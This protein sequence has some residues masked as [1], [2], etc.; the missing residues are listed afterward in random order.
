MNCWSLN[1]LFPS[2]ISLYSLS[3]LFIRTNLSWLIYQSIKAI[4]IKTSVLVNLVFANNAVLSCFLLLF[5]LIIYLYFL[6]AAVIAQIFNPTAKLI[7]P[8]GIPTKES[9]SL[10]ETH[11]VNAEA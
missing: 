1:F 10:I 4:E 8:V 7:I 11:P 3:A 9:K 5:F 6:S 2:F